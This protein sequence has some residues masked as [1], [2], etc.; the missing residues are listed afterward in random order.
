MPQSGRSFRLV[1]E[2]VHTEPGPGRRA[3]GTSWPTCCPAQPEQEISVWNGKP[4][5]CGDSLSARSS[6]PVPSAS[7]SCQH[8]LRPGHTVVCG[9]SEA[10]SNSREQGLLSRRLLR[11]SQ[12]R[13]CPRG[14]HSWRGWRW[15]SRERGCS[16][17]SARQIRPRLTGRWTW[18]NSRLASGR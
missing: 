2:G 13:P 17:T 16:R 18:L 8:G 11:T 12:S 4:L 9:E 5:R 1:P 10:E 7:C 3:E 15:V 6:S 14:A